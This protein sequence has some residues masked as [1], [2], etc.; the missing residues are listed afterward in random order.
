MT[1]DDHTSDNPSGGGTSLEGYFYQVDI[2]VWA[3]LDLLLA[4]KL[5]QQLV[6]DLPAR[7]AR[8][9]RSQ[10]SLLAS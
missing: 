8:S 6:L 1:D 7:K 2:S 5:A 4:K 3:A 9:P 10:V